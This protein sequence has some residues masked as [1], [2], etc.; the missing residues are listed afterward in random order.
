MVNATLLNNYIGPVLVLFILPIIL[1]IVILIFVVRN[2]VPVMHFLYADA[3][4]HAR[5]K[6]MITESLLLELT[7][8]KSLKE[9]RS[10]LRETIYGEALEKTGDSLRSVHVSL[11]EGYINS[12][13]ELIE[14]SPQKSKPLLDSYLMF[15]EI[16]ILKIIYRAKFNKMEIDESFVYTIGNIDSTLLKHL[17]DTETVADIS[18]VMTNTAYSKV[19]EKKYS[20]LEEFEN[21]VDEF[22]FNN[23]VDT[24]KKTKIYDG[25]YIMD[26]LN[27]KIDIYNILALLKFRVRGIEK[28]KQKELLVNNKS[29]LCL[30]FDKL[31][32]SETLKDFAEEFKGL[33]Y[34]E[35]LTKAFEKYEKDHS[36]AHFENELYRLFKKY[37]ADNEMAHTLGPYPLFSYLIKRELELRNLFITSRGID[38][39]FSTEKIKEMIV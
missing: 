25:N 26:I 4:I 3:R 32:N 11:E 37:V 20:T 36:L 21:S 1:A 6:Y 22:V 35:S 9:F 5:S 29:S 28:E 19:F 31:I 2:V 7:E 18:V 12:I 39:E 16:K 14:M 23:F 8:A 27:K 13:Y 24:I 10:L 17:L 38:V 30:R 34:Y 15:L 33:V